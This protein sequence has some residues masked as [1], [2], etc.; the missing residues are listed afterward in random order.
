[1]YGPS[2]MSIQLD[3]DHLKQ[4]KKTMNQGSV[5]APFEQD[6][7]QVHLGFASYMCENKH[8]KAL[9]K[10]GFWCDTDVKRPIYIKGGV[11]AEQVAQIMKLIAKVQYMNI[12]IWSSNGVLRYSKG[13][14][15]TAYQFFTQWL[16]AYLNKL[17]K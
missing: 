6:K 15:E 3:K 7:F 13:G 12:Q 17:A 1:M 5:P 10:M 11:T 2:I 16:N 8:H 4:I 14:H 9:E